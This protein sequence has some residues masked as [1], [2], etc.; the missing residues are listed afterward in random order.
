MRNKILIPSLILGILAAFFS[1]R[2]LGS[3]EQYAGEGQND[4]I[5]QTVMGVMQEGHYS[6]RSLDDS[7]SMKVYDKSIENLDYGKKFF[8]QTDIDQLSAYRLTIDDQIKDNSLEFFDKINTMFVKRVDD[9]K[10][11]YATLLDKPFSFDGNDSVQLDGEKLSFVKTE[12]ELK[13]RWQAQLKY[14]VLAKYRDLKEEDEKKVKDSAGYKAKTFAT[15]EKDA[16]QSVSKIQERY[17]K[18]LVKFNNDDRFALFMNAITGSEDPHTTFMQPTDKKKFDEMMSGSFIGIGATLQQQEDGR[19][20]VTSIV[21][22]SPSW[23]Q[24]KLK[25]EDLIEKVAQGDQTPVDVIGFDLDDVVKMIRG[26]EGTEVR[27]SVKHP[28]GTNEI[29][30]IV[31]A[32][33]ELEDIFAK[34]AIIEDD[35][36]RIG[37]IYLPEFYADF[38]NASGRR[39]S[40]DVEAEVI[41]LM[42]ENVSGIILDLRNNGGGSLSD[43]VDMTG[44]FTGAGPVVQVRGSG[45]QSITLS[46]KQDKP[47]YT[48]PLA[49][50]V[51][52]N[53]ASAS[54]IMAAAIQDY[55]RG[56]V[57]GANSFGKG[58]VQKI[59]PL[60]QF[61]S[62]A[63]RR[64]I[65]EGMIAAKGGEVEYDGIGS[66]K[67][68]IQKFYR[69]NG[70]STQL[71]G[72]VPDVLLPDA[73]ELLEE[74]GERRD[75]SAL[76]W[77][78]ISQVGFEPFFAPSSFTEL[79]TL[80]KRRV[81]ANE[82]FKL[83]MQTAQRIKRQQDNNT[84]PLNEQ[85]YMAKL[86]EA[87]D[88]T[89]KLDELDSMSTGL[90]VVNL[91]A[92][93]S[94]VNVDTAAKA[95]NDNWLK[96]LKKDVYVAE[97]SNVLND[98][99]K[100]AVKV[101]AINNSDR[102]PGVI[103]SKRST[104]TRPE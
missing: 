41:K 39:C 37:Y 90:N 82:N 42:A 43:V 62:P 66:L 92:D 71:K 21:T 3:G 13:D 77:D 49:I 7:F 85:K 16:R 64:Q 68:T 99:I 14:S 78:K 19:V 98:W 38:N 76:A 24:G 65:I 89:A 69:I 34:S 81:D 103:R 72:V 9:A 40:K 8:L 88:I 84:V 33:V 10:K 52:G 73:Y 44:I 45:N 56:V 51:N 35:G 11:F 27:L 86:K 54:E 29:V 31:R 95:K 5:L 93:L 48:G 101:T 47:I 1:F 102:S 67:L 75:K 104:I 22:G 4:I 25:A 60:D 23:K 30:P 28:D 87:K 80:S 74:T 46:A 20:K 26:K 57:I 12:K 53:S 32:K 79:A 94:R 61:V 18:R 70:G 63:A 91:Q 55:K 17:F 6:P 83:V 36:Q 50:M 2:Y 97:A 100:G 96:A 59:V 58:T 15:L